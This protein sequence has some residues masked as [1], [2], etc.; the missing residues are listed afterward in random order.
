MESQN[1]RIGSQIEWR[2]SGIQQC[3]LT[4]V[5]PQYSG[6]LGHGRIDLPSGVRRQEGIGHIQIPRRRKATSFT[7]VRPPKPVTHTF[8]RGGFPMRI[9]TTSQF[10]M[11]CWSA[12]LGGTASYHSSLYKHQH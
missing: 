9:N 3:K 7:L 2:L 4:D 11:F 12:A 8:E 6:K 10:A 5:N 1:E